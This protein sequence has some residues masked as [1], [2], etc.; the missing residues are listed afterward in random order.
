V[1]GGKIGAKET[2]GGKRASKRIAGWWKKKRKRREK[3][4]RVLIHGEVRR[5][6][7]RPERLCEGFMERDG[8]IG[9]G[10]MRGQK[11]APKYDDLEKKKN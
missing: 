4:G 2:Q 11:K 3:M 1:D 6:G 10:T 9:S 5:D 8:G 7:C